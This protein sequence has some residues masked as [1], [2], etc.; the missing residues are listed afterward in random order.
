M[1]HDYRI[2]NQLSTGLLERCTRCGDTKHFP[3]NTPNHIYLSYHIRS[4]LQRNEPRFN[5]EYGKR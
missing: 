5:I 4:S 2:I 3:H 1:L